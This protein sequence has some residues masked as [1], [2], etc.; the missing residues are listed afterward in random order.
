MNNP[1][2][3]PIKYLTKK[4][5]EMDEKEAYAIYLL[6]KNNPGVIQAYEKSKELRSKNA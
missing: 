3:C 4:F 6:I 2:N 1:C 5:L